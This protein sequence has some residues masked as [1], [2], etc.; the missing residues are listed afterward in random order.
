MNSQQIFA[1][2]LAH[3]LAGL[4]ATLVVYAFAVR[5]HQACGRPALLTPV[6]V[7][8]VAMV[9]I[10]GVFDVP[11][12]QYFASAGVLHALLPAAFALLTVAVWRQHRA[13]GRDSVAV[14]LIVPIGAAVGVMGTVLLTLLLHNSAT[15]VATLAVRSITTPVAVPLSES[16]GGIASIAAF[17]V[18]G[19]GVVGATLGPA[20]L[21]RVGVRDE[22]AI[23]LA[24]GV[25]AH[26]IGTAEAVRISER[27][28]AFAVVG[29]VATAFVGTIV[30]L[31]ALGI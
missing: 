14:A 18:I 19:S 28:G 24:L 25:A 22:R 26:A 17:A 27:A 9:A 3:P 12:A 6:F 20:V 15:M 4:T 1:G 30:V 8:I 5:L 21:R 11:H 31:V 23:G 2:G 29:M 7:A 10:L 16:L 13:I